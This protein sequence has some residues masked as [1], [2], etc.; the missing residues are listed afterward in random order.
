M[1]TYNGTNGAD[2]YAAPGAEVNFISGLKGDDTLTGGYLFDSINGGSGADVIRALQGDDLVYG[3]AGNDILIA[4]EGDDTI[5]TG[6]GSNRADGGRG[7]DLFDLRGAAAGEVNTVS[8][9]AGDDEFIAGKADD[10]FDGG[11]GTDLVSYATA[12]GPVSVSLLE[13]FGGGSDAAGD[14]YFG[15]E[16]L[17]ATRYGD[18]LLGDSQVNHLD[19]GKG[20]DTVLGWAGNDLLLGGAGVDLLN[21]GLGADEIDGGAGI[22]TVSYAGD[23]T[24]VTVDLR[25]LVQH[26]S[27]AGDLL[28]S[29]ENVVGSDAGDSIMGSDG[30][31][32][33]NGGFGVDTLDGGA[34]A[35]IFIGG[36]DAADW[37]YNFELGVD[38]ISL[39]VSYDQVDIYDV[40]FD[41]DGVDE[42][43]MIS[44]DGGS[45]FLAFIGSGSISSSDF[46]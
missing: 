43:T 22:D 9:G 14:R 34:G 4:G 29:I 11:V 18:S 10:L 42:G 40:D 32:V 19:A 5:F 41:G 21:G 37:V 16:N 30:A 17:I 33:L 25:F 39:T 2:L 46:V 8:G 24:G 15:I 35:D 31:N 36:A 20:D 45:L 44:S 1:A 23:E 12:R 3:G 28:F 26:G 7:D 13:H 6:S 38:K 27:A